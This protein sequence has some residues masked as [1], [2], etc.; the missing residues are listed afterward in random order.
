MIHQQVLFI[1]DRPNV[2]K[3]VSHDVAF[4]GTSSYKTLLE[5]IY[6]MQLDLNV[7]EV[8]NAYDI[9]GNPR[10]VPSDIKKYKVVALGDEAATA[11]QKVPGLTYFKLPHPSGLNRKL[12][13]VKTLN[14]RLAKCKKFIYAG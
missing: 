2:Q 1:S 4:V 6:K 9:Q 8:I 11:C 12:N 3:N 13:D 5:W 7:V 10:S 14:E